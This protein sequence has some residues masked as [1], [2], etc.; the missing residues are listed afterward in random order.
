MD[1]RL[2]FLESF[3]ATGSDG[4]TYKVRAYERLK[5]VVG[6]QWESTG[7]AEYRLD[8]GR[9]VEVDRNE[10]MRIVG[11]GVQ[12]SPAGARAPA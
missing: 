7:E 6:E 4:A 12:L 9:L 10:T 1:L 11:S 8:D 5:A 3:P 2:R